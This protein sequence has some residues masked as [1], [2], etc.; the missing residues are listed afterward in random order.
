MDRVV[1]QRAFEVAS[2]REN[3]S[4]DAGGTMRLMPE[5][6]MRA[7]HI[8]ARSLITIAY[9][10][11][12]FQLV[13]EPEWARTTYYD[14]EAKPAG[15]ATREQ[16][17]VMMQTLLMDRFKLA[18]HRENRQLDGF[19]LVRARADSLGPNLKPSTVDCEKAFAEVPRCRQGYLRSDSMVA[20]GTP[21][22]SLLQVVI[23]Q[24]RAPVSDDT[25]LSGPFDF[26][27][28]WSNEIAPA[29]D[30]PSIYT[31]LQEQLGLKLERRR[32]VSEVFV[33][34]HLERASPN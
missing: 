3:T 10:L 17:Y 16:T 2:I 8:P 18:F 22:W 1:A 5:G 20:V 4:L 28:H 26:D 23:A 32:V 25:Q 24:V 33:V 29:G 12:P 6:G 7:V 34:D 19:A 30:R 21:I 9:Q 13:G 11:Q 31:A 27:L 15:P 14:I